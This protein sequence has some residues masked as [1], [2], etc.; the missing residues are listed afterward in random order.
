MARVPLVAAGSSPAVDEL[1]A[2]I[3]SLGRPLL[4]L[5]RVLANQPPALAAFLGM[6]RYVRDDSSLDPRLREMAI[7]A[8]ARELGQAYELA[9]HQEVAERLGVSAG[10]LATLSRG[11][12]EGLDQ[13]ELAAVRYARELART[14]DCTEATFAWLRDLLPL[15]GVTDLVVTVAWYHLCAAILGPLHVELEPE[16][17][18]DQA[19]GR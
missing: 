6:S 16:L 1:F 15:E 19:G 5:Y 14:R 13:L 17:R 3:A 4:N 8:T 2:E 12:D 9:H 10:K 11:G 7:I 18:P